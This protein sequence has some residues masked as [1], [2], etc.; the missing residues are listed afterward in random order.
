MEDTV[1]LRS[2]V[3]V[4]AQEGKGYT[5]LFGKTLVGRRTVDADAE[6]LRPRFLKI[7]DTILVRL[8]FFG[9]SGGVSENKERQHHLLPPA[10]IAEL[11]GLAVLIGQFEVGRAVTHFER[12]ANTPSERGGPTPAGPPPLIRNSPD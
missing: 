6:N 8:E 4:V 5:D 9:S 11:H 7:G 2:H 12:H 10:E 1:G 3:R